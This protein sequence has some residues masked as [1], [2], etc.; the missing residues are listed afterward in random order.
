MSTSRFIERGNIAL[1]CD[2]I[3]CEKVL[4]TAVVMK[5]VTFDKTPK[6]ENASK[7]CKVALEKIHPVLH[8]A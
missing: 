8:N 2:R 7:T 3:K 1:D 4:H 6:Q 5:L